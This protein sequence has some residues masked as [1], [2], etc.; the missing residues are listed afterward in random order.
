[1]AT[2]H[3][4]YYP[5]REVALEFP[6]G[7]KRTAIVYP[8]GFVHFKKFTVAL[9]QAFDSANR[10]LSQISLP[11]ALKERLDIAKA[12][13]AAAKKSKD[14]ELLIAS[15]LIFQEA[16]K[17]LN[18]LIVKEIL[19]TMLPVVIGDLMD[20][21]AECTKGVDVKRLAHWHVAPIAEAW[22]E[23]SFA[24]IKKLEPWIQM[25]DNLLEK[26]TGTKMNLW[27]KLLRFSSPSDTPPSTSSIAASL[28]SLIE[29]GL[30]PSST[31]A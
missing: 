25:I 23:E 11:T 31:S 15:T 24:D 18:S 16:E 21:V 10:I 28:D 27:D 9:T 7:V 4:V 14:P 29:A 22:I 3:D 17:E 8:V 2:E 20:L 26:M 30:S 13:V 5:G 19:R 6:N 1:M 12:D